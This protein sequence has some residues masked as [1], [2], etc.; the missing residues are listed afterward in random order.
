MSIVS[1]LSL[2]SDA[3]SYKI[4]TINLYGWLSNI[5]IKNIMFKYLNSKLIFTY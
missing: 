5:I 2:I 4:S 1:K 3:F